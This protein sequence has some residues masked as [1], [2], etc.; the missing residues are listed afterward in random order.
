M[1][2]KVKITARFLKRK[3]AEYEQLQVEIEQLKS[4]VSSSGSSLKDSALNSFEVLY[5]TYQIFATF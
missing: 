5:G 3:M 4:E 2:E 1:T